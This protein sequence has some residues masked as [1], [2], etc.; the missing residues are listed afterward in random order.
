MYEQST[1]GTFKTKKREWDFSI[2]QTRDRKV[3]AKMQPSFSFNIKKLKNLKFSKIIGGSSEKDR[4]LCFSLSCQVQNGLMMRYS[5]MEI[6]TA[7]IQA[8]SLSNN[9][10]T[11]LVS[12]PVLKSSLWIGI[13]GSH[14]KE[15]DSTTTFAEHCNAS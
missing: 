3:Q 8:I 13:L 4:L 14:Y 1:N 2:Y 6:S 12:N 11:Y 5:N 15:K 7:V 10:Q 9:L